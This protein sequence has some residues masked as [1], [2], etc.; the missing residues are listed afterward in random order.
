MT[1]EEK[2]QVI[3]ILTKKINNASHIYVTNSLGLSASDTVN[4]RKECYKNEIELVVAKNTL[5]IKAIEKSDKELSELFEVLKGET[6]IMFTEVGNRPAKLIKEFREKN[7]LEKPVLKGAYVEEGFYFGDNQIDTL[8]AIKSKEELIADVIGLLQAPVVNV[9][10]ALESGG[11]T[12]S[13]ILKTLE[14]KE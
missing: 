3:D 7:K 13:G 2:N 11:N 4:L 14:E 5:L 12:I 6:S 10:S 1:R 8:V 9:L